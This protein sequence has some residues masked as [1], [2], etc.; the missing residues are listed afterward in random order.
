MPK[1]NRL[2]TW[3]FLVKREVT[4]ESLTYSP[5]F[6]K[7]EVPKTSTM[8]KLLLILL[9]TTTLNAL[10]RVLFIGNSYTAANSLPLW[11]GRYHL[12]SDSI[13][14]NI[15]Y[16]WRCA[17]AYWPEEIGPI[18]AS[19][20]SLLNTLHSGWQKTL[21]RR[22]REYPCTTSQ[23]QLPRHPGSYMG[24]RSKNTEKTVLTIEPSAVRWVM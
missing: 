1:P 20:S 11:Q 12:Y 18:L 22:F 14:G 23:I 10:E 9:L 13:N 16:R 19:R 6:I 7:L 4:K 5:L 2:H 15:R 8:R 21:E 17:T 3:R 24:K